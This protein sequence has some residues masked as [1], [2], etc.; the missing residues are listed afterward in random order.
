MPTFVS[1]QKSF[2]KG[3]ISKAKLMKLDQD[4]NHSALK[5]TNYIV[6][7]DDSISPRLGFKRISSLSSHLLTSYKDLVYFKGIYVFIKDKSLYLK[8]GK[9]EKRISFDYS[10]IKTFF[11]SD[12]SSGPEVSLDFGIR[13]EH[14]SNLLVKNLKVVNDEVYIFLENSYPFK[15]FIQNN[16][17]AVAPFYAESDFTSRILNI[18][19]KFPFFLLEKHIKVGDFFKFIYN[20]EYFSYYSS[21]LNPNLVIFKE[22]LEENECY[23]CLDPG[24]RGNSKLLGQD[25]FVNLNEVSLRKYLGIPIIF[26]IGDKEISQERLLYQGNT[27]IINST[28]KRVAK[29]IY[30]TDNYL[31]W[32]EEKKEEDIFLPSK[33]VLP[34]F[35]PVGFRFY[36]IIP[37]EYI[38]WKGTSS[39]N[40]SAQEYYEGIENNQWGGTLDNIGGYVKC[41]IFELGYKTNQIYQNNNNNVRIIG[42]RNYNFPSQSL[43]DGNDPVPINYTENFIVSDWKDSF[44]IDGGFIE[45]RNFFITSDGN[46]SFSKVNK[47]NDFSNAIK[48]LLIS[49]LGKYRYGSSFFGSPRILDFV[50]IQSS[51][52]KFYDFLSEVEKA[53]DSVILNNSDAFSAKIRD[54]NGNVFDI[55]SYVRTNYDINDREGNQLVLST[56]NGIYQISLNSRNSLENLFNIRK[57]TDFISSSKI[58]IISIHNNIYISPGDGIYNANYFEGNKAYIFNI[59]SK[60]FIIKNIKKIIS[61]TDDRILIITENGKLFLANYLVNGL[62]SGFSEWKVSNYIFY[63]ILKTNDQFL[64][65]LKNKENSNLY[66]FQYGD[67]EDEQK[68]FAEVSIL[69]PNFS[70]G[71]FHNFSDSIQ[72]R[73]IYIIGNNLEK[74]DFS[75]KIDNQDN[76]QP[77]ISLDSYN[78]DNMISKNFGVKKIILGSI[79]EYN[80]ILSFR[81]SLGAN[82]DGLL[83]KFAGF[84]LICNRNNI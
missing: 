70:K 42:G 34:L 76:S 53:K 67:L 41:K 27:K 81:Q 5:L 63:D 18:E 15:L 3:E 83:S 75:Y 9:N 19:N 8:F 62:I 22:N 39:V 36:M 4:Y 59:S 10:F 29:N 74:T 43:T 33:S 6:N 37:Y 50:K 16:L 46:I 28:L 73:E 48:T 31:N 40:I 45:N 77:W 82:S 54:E 58:P 32:D 60:D 61:F 80:K 57:V 11:L 1:D 71:L 7:K 64:F 84:S 68:D 30:G 78:L 52:G 24:Y 26:S 38:S 44:P 12:G 25:F 51:S 79:I 69:P 20:N 23:A 56:S 65:I 13:N 2:S 14:F 21:S 47:N 72:L 66:I 17:I 35:L 55:Y 49:N